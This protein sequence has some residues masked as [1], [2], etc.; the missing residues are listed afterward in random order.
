[1][2]N[3]TSLF[4]SRGAEL[5]L[6]AFGASLQAFVGSCC[7]KRFGDP[8][9]QA[10]SLSVIKFVFIVGLVVNL[11]SSNIGIWALNTFNSAYNS[12]NYWVDVL[13]WWMGDSLGVLL[14][15]PL[16]LSL[17]R[18][19]ESNSDHKKPIWVVV[20][21]T[22]LLSCMV[23]TLTAFFISLS[24]DAME[25]LTA[26]EVKNIENSFYAQHFYLQR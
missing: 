4:S 6:I 19:R 3:V 16:L 17:L 25:K 12:E 2:G 10:S 13:Y 20:S 11:I 8:I 1:M 14:M 9:S 21:A 23:L 7:L 24:N 18:V 15:A 26:K 22:L 5:L